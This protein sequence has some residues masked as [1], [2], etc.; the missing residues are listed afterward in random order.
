M[1]APARRGTKRPPRWATLGWFTPTGIDGGVEA[2][3]GQQWRLQL[4]ARP[5]QVPE[6]RHDVVEV[7]ARE[8]PGVD[9]WTAALVV[10][11]LATNVVTH[12]YVEPGSLEVEVV[13]EP[14]AVVVTVR[15]WGRGFGR[16][17]RHGMGMGLQLVA[18]LAT[19]LWVRG[20]QPTEVKARLPRTH[21]S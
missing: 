6:A 13:C 11:E 16:S 17:G 18:A 3:G 4:E 20:F 1:Y 2:L 15:D 10:T 14:D 8:C 9:L 5:G 19:R 12:A 7:L 21:A